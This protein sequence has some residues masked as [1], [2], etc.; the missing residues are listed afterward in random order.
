MILGRF[1]HEVNID[2]FMNFLIN[3]TVTILVIVFVIV[4]ENLN[5]D[6]TIQQ[7]LIHLILIY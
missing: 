1:W 4:V 5:L 3:L 2:F 6:P 7:H